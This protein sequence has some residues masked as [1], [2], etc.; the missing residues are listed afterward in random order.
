MEEVHRSSDSCTS[1]GH[2][3]QKDQG[4]AKS[5]SALRAFS[6]WNQRLA[7]IQSWELSQPALWQSQG[8]K[9]EKLLTTL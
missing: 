3:P 2:A 1:V 8:V 5:G 7:T 9:S 6:C 4:R